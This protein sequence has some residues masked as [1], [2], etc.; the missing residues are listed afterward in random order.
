MS[1]PAWVAFGIAL[2]T[3]N[4]ARMERVV[5]AVVSSCLVVGAICL[6]LATRP[7]TCVALPDI[8]DPNA[9]GVS[10][11][12]PCAT[13]A[14]CWHDPPD[15]EAS[16]RCER[17]GPFG[18]RTVDGGRVRH[19]GVL[20]DPN[21][22]AL[23]LALA[24]PLAFGL[25]KQR[26]HSRATASLCVATIAVAAL[27]VFLSGS[28]SGV[29]ALAVVPFAYTLAGR[30]ARHLLG[31]ALLA[32]PIILVGGRT[33]ERAAAS[34]SERLEAWYEALSMFREHPLLG[35]GRDQFLVHH[36]LTAHN[37]PLLAAAEDGFIG[38][39]LWIALFL[40][41]LGLVP[42]LTRRAYAI[43]QSAHMTWRN[44]V[45]SALAALIVGSIFLSLNRHVLT[46]VHVGLA[47][48]AAGTQGGSTP[49]NGA[50]R[51]GDWVASAAAGIGT[52]VLAW[53][54][55]HLSQ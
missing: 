12:R 6:Q 18:N 26:R 48:A 51:F 36:H 42:R 37:S 15:P 11:G 22:V 50:P 43:D 1:V 34:T 39:T 17:V 27:V 4:S 47:A 30:P 32:V 45:R 7:L 46:W 14:E 53:V 29:L 21:E 19:V 3:T 10:D 35:V 38:L 25:K 40:A 13:V 8:G 33:G 28:R 54:A 9:E 5:L 44:A 20:S 31:A 24:V 41:A 2:T 52:L 16:Y 23:A 55:I 49:N